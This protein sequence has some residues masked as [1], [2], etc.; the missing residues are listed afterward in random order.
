M[1]NTGNW[2]QIAD[3][4][5]ANSIVGI[6]FSN[7]TKGYVGVPENNETHRVPYMNMILASNAWRKVKMFPS[8][9]SLE[10]SS[11]YVDDRSFVLGGWWSETTSQVW[12]F[13]P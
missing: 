1:R 9:S 12:E 5:E 8:G 3:F 13:I 4:P 10:T 11:F 7:A 6:L 2:T